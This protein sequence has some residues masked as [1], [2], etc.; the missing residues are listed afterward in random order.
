MFSGCKGEVVTYA[1][2]QPLP[3]HSLH[4]H[5]DRCFC[6]TQFTSVRKSIPEIMT[7]LLNCCNCRGIKLHIMKQNEKRKSQK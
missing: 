3:H 2:L 4:S 7:E 6:P 1:A 5:L